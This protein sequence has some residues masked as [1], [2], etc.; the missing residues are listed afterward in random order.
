MSNDPFIEKALAA[1]RAMDFEII[2][3]LR[4]EIKPAHV[5]TL[6]QTWNR[7]LPWG[8]KDAYAALLMDQTG[9]TVKE[10]MED[11]LGSPTAET[12]A[13]AICILKND[14]NLFSD[15]LVD[16]GVDASKVDAAIA[17]YRS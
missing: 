4:D 2:E 6:L 17:A 13:Y 11:A 10:F 14:F 7:D 1:I 15:F 16:G 3:G 5:P 8:V 12:R 9:G